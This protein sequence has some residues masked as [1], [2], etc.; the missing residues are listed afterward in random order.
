MNDES[1]N[2]DIYQAATNPKLAVCLSGAPRFP[3]PGYPESL[4]WIKAPALG[5]WK[6]QE[7][8]YA[9][10]RELPGRLQDVIRARFGQE[11]TLENYGRQI[12]R[13]KERVRQLEAQALR[14]LRGKLGGD[15]LFALSAA[16]E[17]VPLPG[18]ALDPDWVD[19]RQA[20][21]L[22]G[23]TR[24]HVR[25]LCRQKY[26]VCQINPLKRDRY[27]I[28]RESLE[29]YVKSRPRDGRKTGKWEDQDHA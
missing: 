24:Q 29:A 13:T 15:I 26:V 3:R 20:H 21:E 2:G 1:G 17:V 22:T 4:E 6:L 18:S 28:S 7:T 9:A 8:V 23:Y 19:T 5:I 25:W 14:V 16:T 10:I 11:M 27:Q 12:G